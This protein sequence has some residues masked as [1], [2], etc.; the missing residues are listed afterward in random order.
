MSSSTV[1]ADVVTDWNQTALK[2]TEVAGMGPPVQARAMA[3]VHAAIYDAVNALDRRHSAYAVT[4]TVPPGASIDSAAAAAAHGALVR[5]F[6]PQQA[7]IDAALA[8]SL[9]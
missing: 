8:T 4:V 2:A 6:P 1:W 9:G 7:M 3:I 5:L